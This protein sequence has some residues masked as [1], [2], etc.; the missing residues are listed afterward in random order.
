[1]AEIRDDMP[2]RL[3]E[4]EI[5]VLLKTGA[6]GYE[7]KLGPRERAALDSALGTLNSVLVQHQD[8]IRQA[9]EKHAA[10]ERR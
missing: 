4:P 9:K 2:I 6:L 3:T 7:S 8:L 5:R 1:M 10:Q